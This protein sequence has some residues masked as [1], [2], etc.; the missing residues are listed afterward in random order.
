[1]WH[2]RRKNM[3]WETAVISGNLSYGIDV[4]PG[5]TKAKDMIELGGYIYPW[6]F[7]AKQRK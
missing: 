5:K 3:P 2:E 1:M 6:Y 7:W 4:Q